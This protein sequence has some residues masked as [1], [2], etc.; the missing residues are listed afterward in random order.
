MQSDRHIKIEIP[1]RFFSDLEEKPFEICQVCGKSLLKEGVSYV[2]EKAIKNYPGHDFSS[3]IYEMAICV[4]CHKEIQKSMSQES[5][6][7]LQL[8]YQSVMEKKGHQP[9]II[10]LNTFNLDAWLSTCFF[11]GGEIKD[12]DEYQ[13]VA[14]FEGDKMLLTMPPMVIGSAAMGEMAALMSEKTTDEMNDF[15]NRFMGPSPELEELI[16]GKKLFLL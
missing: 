14:Q 15:R 7:N 10:D 1:A 4:D 12:M 11:K 8:Y 2:V 9:M 16:H 13:V 5:M 3:T 6:Q